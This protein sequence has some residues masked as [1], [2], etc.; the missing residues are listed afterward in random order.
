MDSACTTPEAR[1]YQRWML[2]LI[3]PTLAAIWGSSWVL[4]NR[5]LDPPARLAVALV[6]VVLWGVM[7]M[8]L[9]AGVRRLDELQQRIQL[10]AL[11][12]T[13]PTAMMLGMLVEYL[14]KAGFA[15]GLTVGDVWPWMVMI[16]VPAYFLARWRY[17]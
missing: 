14:Q 2:L 4:E 17:R 1:R 9:V 7:I 13:F 8:L 12:I 6:P 5:A 11:A 15:N 10:E 16:Y 3:V